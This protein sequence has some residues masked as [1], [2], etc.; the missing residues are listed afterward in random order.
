MERNLTLINYLRKLSPLLEKIIDKAL[1]ENIRI[2]ETQELFQ[3]TSRH[4][5][6]PKWDKATILGA[7]HFPQ[8]GLPRIIIVSLSEIKKIAKVALGIVEIGFAHEIAHNLT[9]ENRPDCAVY[10]DSSFLIPVFTPCSY[11]EPLAYYLALQIID[12]L[13]RGLPDFKPPLF[14]GKRMTYLEI[15]HHYRI[16][17]CYF[18]RSKKC[19]G[20][21]SHQL[22]QCPKEKEI[23]KL[24]RAID[25]YKN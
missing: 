6:L 2:L 9:W 7:G 18:E 4:F 21:K 10:K 5:S 22:K 11:F 1:R 13:K 14:Y 20:I 23:K 24:A 3:L 12:E 16:P 8:I 17:H 19:D 15:L 25:K